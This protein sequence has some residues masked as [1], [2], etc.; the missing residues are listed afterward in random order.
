MQRSKAFTLIELLVVIAIIAILAAILFPVFAQAKAAAKKTVCL[1]NEKQ[2]GTA[3]V[4]YAG[5]YDDYF[6][7][8]ELGTMTATTSAGGT[9][10]HSLSWLVAIQPYA[11]K[12]RITD[13]GKSV[14]KNDESGSSVQMFICPGQPSDPRAGRTSSGGPRPETAGVGVSY[15]L[16]GSFHTVRSQSEFPNVA[17]TIMASEQYQ[18]F[19]N[20]YYY[21]VDWEGTFGGTVHEYGPGR[22]DATSDCRFDRDTDCSNSGGAVKGDPSRMPGITGFVSNIAYWHDKGANMVFVDGHAKFTNKAATYKTDGSFSM[23]TLSNMWCRRGS[24]SCPNP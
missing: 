20:T 4:M 18:N 5:D 9:M 14:G 7:K 24:T 17:G 1:S 10:T 11:Q 15:A 16:P 6:P 13:R 21:P 8:D 2:V 22:V 23:W 3:M 19:V 12:A